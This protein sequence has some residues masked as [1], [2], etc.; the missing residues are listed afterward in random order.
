MLISCPGIIVDL[1]FRDFKLRHYHIVVN[2]SITAGNN[3]DIDAD[4]NFSQTGGTITADGTLITIDSVG[5]NVDYIDLVATG[6]E[7]RLHSL[8]GDIDDG[9]AEVLDAARAVFRAPQ[10][11]VGS[12]G[13]LDTDL[14][15][16]GAAGTVAATAGNRV[17]IINT[18]VGPGLIIGTVDSLSGVSAGVTPGLVRDAI[19]ISNTPL[20]V[21]SPMS[22]SAGGDIT[23][24]AEGVLATDDLTINANVTATGGNGNILLYAGD[25]IA[26]NTTAVISAVGL[27]T[28]DFFA[29]VDFNTGGVPVDVG[30]AGDILMGDGSSTTSAGGKIELQAPNNITLSSVNAVGGMVVVNAD[31]SAIAN[32]AD[33]G[34]G[35]ITDGTLLEA[36]NVSGLSVAFRAGSGIGDAAVDDSDIDVAVANLAA[37][38]ATG[39]ISIEDPGGAL[40]TAIVDGLPG[41]SIS[42][43][44]GGD[45]IL[46]REGVV[47]LDFTI[48]TGADVTNSGTGDITLVSL[49]TTGNDELE[50]RGN[51]TG[52]GG[53]VLIIAQDDVFLA[54]GV[55]GTGI[56]STTGTGTVDLIAG[57]NFAF[58]GPPFAVGQDDG[59]IFMNQVGSAVRTDEGKITLEAT[60]DVVLMSLNA[61]FD[62]IG[63]VGDVSVTADSDGNALGNIID[64]LLGAEGA[65]GGENII[66]A[67]ITLNAAEGIG[68][69][70]GLPGEDSDIDIN[71]VTLTATNTDSGSIQV[72]EIDD[73]AIASVDNTGRPVVIEAGGAITDDVPDAVADVTGST[74]NL[75]AAAGGIGQGANGSLDV[76]A[77]VQLDA[78]TTGD[79][80]DID[81]FAPAL[82]MPL[83][84][85]NT[86]SNAAGSVT[87][88]AN[89]GSILEAVPGP[90]V[91]IRGGTLSLTAS[92]RVGTIGVFGNNTVAVVDGNDIDVDAISLIDIGAGEVAHITHTT[93]VPINLNGGPTINEAGA[94]AEEIIIRTIQSD[95][96]AGTAGA[97]INLDLLDS[98][99]LLSGRIGLN[100]GTLTIPDAGLT[101]ANLNLVGVFDVV[102]PAGR[103][104][105]PLTATD[106][107]F[108]S[109]AAGGDTT[110]NTDVATVDATLTGPANL[111][112]NETD[113]ITLTNLD[114]NNGSIIVATAG[115]GDVG[116]VNVVAGSGGVPGGVTINVFSGAITDQKP[117]EGALNLNIS[118]AALD[119]NATTGIGANV[120]PALGQDED[121]DISATSLDA[122]NTV[123]GSIQIFE[124]DD[125][126][127]GVVTNGLRPIIIESG[128]GALTDGNGG[129]VNITGGDLILVAP[130]GIGDVTDFPNSDET[131][132][133]GGDAIEMDIVTLVLVSTTTGDLHLED[134]DTFTVADNPGAVVVGNA[135]FAEGILRVLNG[136]LDMAGANTTILLDN[137]DNLGLFANTGA[138][139]IPHLGLSTGGDLR[140]IGTTD[141]VDAGATP[142]T[143]ELDADD[144]LIESG[145]TGGDTT[146]NTGVTTIIADFE[147]LT[148]L[149]DAALTI[150]EDDGITLTNVDTFDGDVTVN[151]AATGDVQVNTVVAGSGGTAR[152]VT[153]NVADGAIT[154]ANAGGEG[155]GFINISG[156]AIDLDA[157]TGIGANVAP[158]LGQDEDID[159]SATSLDAA[160]T[161][162]GSIQ[163]FEEDDLALGLVSNNGVAPR[164]VVIEL[165]AGGA[166]TDGNGAAPN[167]VSS[168][169]SIVGPNGIGTVASFPTSDETP[170]S[171]GDAIEMDIVT[172]V[173]ATTTMGDMHLEDVNTFTVANTVG[174]VVVGAGFTRSGI[175]RALDGDLAMGGATTTITLDNDDNLGLFARDIGSGDGTLTIPDLGLQTG[176]AGDLRLIGTEDVIDSSGRV[177][178]LLQGNDLFFRSGN[179]GGATLTELDVELNTIDAV[180]NGA[181]N[182][183]VDE[184]TGIALTNVQTAD[185]AILVDAAGAI[186]AINVVSQTSSAVNDIVIRTT[187]AAD[188]EVDTIDAGASG[189]VGL[190]SLGAITDAG[191]TSAITAEGVALS[192]QTGIGDVGASLP[193]QTTAARLAAD[194]DTGDIHVLNTGDLSIE[195]V[196]A[197]AFTSG[198][199]P[200]DLTSNNVVI[201][202]GGVGDDI[203]IIAASALNMNATVTNNGGGNITLAA[204][205]GTDMDTMAVNANVT[206]AGGA[207][208]IEL[209]AGGTI[210]I[211][212]LIKISAATTGAVD[213]F[214]G[215]DFQDEFT[216]D[217]TLNFAVGVDA[218]V[219]MGVSAEIA[220]EDGAID[221]F[222]TNDVNLNLVDAD[223]DVFGPRGDV[224]VIANAENTA[225]GAPDNGDGDIFDRKG[226]GRSDNP[227]D[228]NIIA[229]NLSLSGA[230]VVGTVTDFA[231]EMGEAIEIDLTSLQV[232]IT[233]TDTGGQMFLHILGDSTITGTIVLGIPAAN[234]VTGI[235]SATGDIDGSGGTI[236]L[237]NDNF[238]MH[239]GT[240]G[241]GTLTIPNGNGPPGPAPLV[242]ID[243]TSGNLRL[244]GRD[245]HCGRRCGT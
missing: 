170:G 235:I 83:G 180:L 214:A 106:L 96:D 201:T 52:A 61:N 177:L 244:I 110:L 99:G 42:T 3:V 25:T 127:L 203:S 228:L 221:V 74:V 38:T 162:S 102:D 240:D 28:I 104:L 230:D 149:N 239:A 187:A 65:G 49:G 76:V 75:I 190:D 117:G 186:T 128:S 120:A 90:G 167:I 111:T 145:A 140:L 82:D 116:V 86:G 175:L 58:A 222:A 135:N 124:V 80:G 79:N 27:G 173:Q 126:A 114:T 81:I 16:G 41:I 184:V 30:S 231:A 157:T 53:N 92:Q 7:I 161:V 60:D 183:F 243:N 101:A 197:T 193:I 212:D 8:T 14:V 33:T 48:G 15:N 72:F 219:N 45:N 188:I 164:P 129:A 204:D 174:A 138:L 43:G 141:V 115:A 119:L 22:D 151:T 133:S 216:T 144:L 11:S 176:A 66:G 100:G 50:V 215:Y 23:L 229:N 226:D 136:N 156:A 158:A 241:A 29:G 6:D 148:P 200:L 169:L 63:P 105:G 88:I 210:T 21:N 40:S 218:D 39:D 160:N 131:A 51:V 94:T 122:A 84:L 194:T 213:V 5:G 185:G 225:G 224:R 238:G 37:T 44:G 152:D 211:A 155:T 55:L 59:D 68:S 108:I 121:I 143:L 62:G 130:N 199:V 20:I 166:L 107:F 147:D 132:G 2:E 13:P 69:G 24:A 171:G 205:G 232:G 165:G 91:N 17:H 118:G 182:L 207:G 36:A 103:D 70:T 208:D 139:M 109:G 206:A 12:V 181:G 196:T 78:D 178:G 113:G 18:N 26:T 179:A 123:S 191:G 209:V 142:R 192:A 242:S 125:L 217:E 195:P 77:S 93:I 34:V 10:G 154:D 89:D 57:R 172:L 85:V 220:S 64:Q 137:N 19:V 4:G 150:N 54:N 67:A 97:E 202:T 153:I 95:L 223:D 237:L 134:I 189:Q 159:I 31:F 163:I 32:T 198:G 168:D 56:I 1:G 87:L 71:G 112:V 9:G 35:A 47:G 227:A 234:A 146:L 46:I 236:I 245:R 233:V 98:L 73:I